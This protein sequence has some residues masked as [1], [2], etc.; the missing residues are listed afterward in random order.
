ME[1]LKKIALFYSEGFQNMKVGKKLWLIIGI[2]L[3][4]FFVILKLFFFPNILQTQ[5]SNDEDR[6]NFVIEN[7]TKQKE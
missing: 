3:F 4:I 1:I 7:L 2:K 5:F 6:A